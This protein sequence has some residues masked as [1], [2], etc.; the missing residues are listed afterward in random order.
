MWVS[1]MGEGSQKVQTASYEVNIS[2]K[3]VMYSKVTTINNAILH[4]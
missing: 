3:E 1:K 4:I 2:H